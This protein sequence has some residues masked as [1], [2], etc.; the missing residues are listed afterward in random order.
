MAFI[1][2]HRHFSDCFSQKEARLCFDVEKAGDVQYG[3]WQRNELMN[4]FNKNFPEGL[5]GWVRQI[6]GSE[7]MDAETA[8]QLM[9]LEKWISAFRDENLFKTAQSKELKK[10][11]G[12][13]EYLLTLSPRERQE[14]F[15][16]F[17]TGVIPEDARSLRS[18]QSMFAGKGP[19][20]KLQSV[21]EN[22]GTLM[23]TVEKMYG[24]KEFSQGNAAS[25]SDA[26]AKESLKQIL[27]MVDSDGKRVAASGAMLEEFRKQAGQTPGRL[28]PEGILDSLPKGGKTA[29]LLRGA[30]QSGELNQERITEL[31]LPKLDTVIQ[32]RQEKGAEQRR[33]IEEITRAS[34][35]EIRKGSETLGDR[36]NEAPGWMKLAIIAGL[37]GG[38]M[39][40][41][42]TAMTIGVLYAGNYFLLKDDH[43]MDSLGK[44]ADMVV[45]YFRGKGLPQ[46]GESKAVEQLGDQVLSFIPDRAREEINSSVTGFTLLS[47]LDI[48]LLATHF[49]T[50]D[51]SGRSG[52]LRAWDQPMR[53]A[54]TASLQGR[55]L[56]TAAARRFFP[57]GDPRTERA[58]DKS[59]QEKMNGLRDTGDALAS[60]FYLLGEKRVLAGNQLN[61]TLDIATVRLIEE[62]R[63]TNTTSGYYDDIDDELSKDHFQRGSVNVRE[64]YYKVMLEGIE[65]A[66]SRPGVTLGQLMQEL[67]AVPSID[68]G[69]EAN[70]RQRK[71][72]KE[73][74]PATEAKPSKEVD[75]KEPND[76]K[77]SDKPSAEPATEGKP[78]KEVEPKE[79]N[80]GKPSGKPSASQSREEASEYKPNPNA[81]KDGQNESKPDPKSSSGAK[82]SQNPQPRGQSNGKNR[83]NLQGNSARE[84]Q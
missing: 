67:A 42:K 52:T 37:I 45:D 1:P 24:M 41:P 60:V 38:A 2:S 17:V 56:D 51:P 74:K 77:P 31:I 13:K 79:P 7:K 66:K 53:T 35:E 70:D 29:S 75:P 32:E 16:D 44:R 40:F 14:R 19:E 4:E 9:S 81:S 36:F 6:M 11:W 82:D 26:L 47:G 28:T 33:K 10:G 23:D 69:T 55:S 80:D 84:A 8:A 59:D 3:D 22:R 54:I 57:S 64:E 48:N 58:S 15:R 25:P 18:A 30:V 73:G 39:K 68:T 65:E 63:K 62:A 49:E 5:V 34:R 61:P 12:P 83:S 43:P 76:G 78:N 50:D 20:Q 71:S 21:V 46:L 27:Y 72:S